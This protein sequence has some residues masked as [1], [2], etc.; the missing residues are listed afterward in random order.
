MVRRVGILALAAF[1]AR[2]FGRGGFGSRGCGRFQG[3]GDAL[4]AE[5]GFVAGL[6]VG[7]YRAFG[8]IVG[9]AA[10]WGKG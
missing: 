5:L 10:G 4:A 1:V 3:G 2:R 8:E 6:A 9:A 7:V